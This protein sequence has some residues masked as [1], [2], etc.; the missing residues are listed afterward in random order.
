M[1]QAETG[2]FSIELRGSI[3]TLSGMTQALPDVF[4]SLEINIF[5]NSPVHRLH[6]LQNDECFVCQ[7]PPL[8][9]LL[10]SF[11]C[12]EGTRPQ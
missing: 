7:Q 9:S 3:P 4:F 8:P 1:V 2:L 11:L 12:G 6:V 10:V 5:F